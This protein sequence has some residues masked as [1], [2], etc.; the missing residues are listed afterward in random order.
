MKDYNPCGGTHFITVNVDPKPKLDAN[1]SFTCLYPTATLNASFTPTETATQDMVN[2]GARW[3]N[4]SSV[5]SW[6][7]S[8]NGYSSNEQNPTITNFSGSD[9]GDYTVTITDNNGCSTS[10]TV[11]IQFVDSDGDGIPDVCD[12]NAVN[13][14]IKIPVNT[15]VTDN[16]MENDV[17]DKTDT[18]IK[19]TGAEYHNSAGVF[20]PL[21]ID[22]TTLPCL[23]CKRYVSRQSSP[24]ITVSTL[25]PK[26]TYRAGSAEH[27]ISILFTVQQAPL[28]LLSMYFRKAT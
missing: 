28:Y 14:N 3:S 9:Y 6:L 16:V 26:P 12:I 24:R 22:A 25:H 5:T 8:T 20:T 2:L 11:N 18:N 15:N 27:T 4:S 7:W 1:I 10:K 19:V 21:M 23:Y 13:D 17:Y